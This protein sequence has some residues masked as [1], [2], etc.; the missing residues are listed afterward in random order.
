MGG[1]LERESVV[2]GSGISGMNGGCLLIKGLDLMVVGFDPI[3]QVNLFFFDQ[4][5]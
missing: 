4:G 5:L 1:F 3:Q 2:L